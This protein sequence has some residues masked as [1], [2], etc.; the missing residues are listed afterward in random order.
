MYL[1][2]FKTLCVRNQ[3]EASKVLGITPQWLSTVCARKVKV[4]KLMAYS[5][6]KYI[7]SNAEIEDYF[8]RVD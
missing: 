2:K 8:E 4:R 6:T 3:K 1:W 5:I 7:D